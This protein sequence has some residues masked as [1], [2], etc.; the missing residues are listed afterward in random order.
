MGQYFEIVNIDKK[1]M[2]HPHCFGDGLKF[3]EIA[4]SDCGILAGLSLLIHQSGDL[5]GMPTHGQ[6]KDGVLLKEAILGS[7]AGDRIVMVGDYDDSNL[8]GDESYKNI[9]HE[10]LEILESDPWVKAHRAEGKRFPCRCEKTDEEW[11]NE[12]KASRGIA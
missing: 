6:V 8:Y 9:S 5:S 12:V 1:E 7:W 10:V 3:W 4:V 2:L 11:I